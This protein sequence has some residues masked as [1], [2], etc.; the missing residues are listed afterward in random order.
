M[1]LLKAC[2][3]PVLEGNNNIQTRSFGETI[4]TI[5]ET[6]YFK[7]QHRC[8]DSKN[9]SGFGLSKN[10]NNEG[11]NEAIYTQVIIQ[12]LNSG[13]GSGGSGGSGGEPV[14]TI[15]AWSGSAAT[16][17]SGYQLCDGGVAQTDALSAITGTNV[18]D[19]TSRFIIGVDNVRCNG[20]YPGVG[21]GSTGGSADAVLIAHRHT[22]DDYVGRGS[23]WWSNNFARGIKM[24]LN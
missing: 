12:D 14:G 10:F 11:T 8:Q 15:V 23:K 4:I 6:T 7:I 16:I 18:P 5:T 24:V 19:L 9:V 13:G 3:D 1:E 21:V 17:P 2:F 22:T 20:T